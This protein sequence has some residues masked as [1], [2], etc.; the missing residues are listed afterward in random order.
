MNPEPEMIAPGV[1]IGR[2]TTKAGEP[3]YLRMELIIEEN[4]L[5]W[6]QYKIHSTMMAADNSRSVLGYLATKSTKITES[7]GSIRYEYN[8]PISESILK[9]IGFDEAELN[10]FICYLGKQGFI[11]N[12]QAQ[13][14]LLANSAGSNHMAL[15]E[16][17][18]RYVVYV[19]QTPDFSIL[20]KKPYVY[21]E[22]L[23]LKEYITQYRELLMCVG[24]DF[25][26][27]EVFR[28]RGIFRNPISVIDHT[29]KGISMVLHAFSGAVAK[30]YFP[31]KKEMQVRPVGAMEL[32]LCQSLKAEAIRIDG[33]TVQDVLI[34][35]K[36]TDPE[37]KSY[38]IKVDALA[39][40]YHSFNIHLDQE[41]DLS[42]DFRPK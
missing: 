20:S 2:A 23:S 11:G 29:Y 19:T 40:Y 13:R 36:M 17:D 38:H 35:V 37:T 27:I 3:I 10:E 9:Y 6:Q 39:D 25:S 5:Y 41:A 1:F 16:N 24:S 8:G 7:D 22:I 4:K 21:G 26:G 42:S 34:N 33:S 30:K 18:Q 31:E 12:E 28:N 14:V 32:I 15:L